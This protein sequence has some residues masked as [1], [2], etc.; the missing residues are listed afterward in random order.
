[1]GE[2]RRGRGSEIK[3]GSRVHEDRSGRK[4][5]I[6]KDPITRNTPPEYDRLM[7][8]SPNFSLSLASVHR[9]GSWL[10]PEGA[11]AESSDGATGQRDLVGLMVVLG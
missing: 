3:D 5:T 7:T 1:M 10:S 11:A 2:W 8:F 6:N 9:C 4:K